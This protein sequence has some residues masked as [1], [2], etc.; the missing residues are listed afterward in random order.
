MHKIVVGQTVF[1]YGMARRNFPAF[2]TARYLM[3]RPKKERVCLVGSGNWYVCR[4][5]SMRI[6]FFFDTLCR[7]S[8]V[9]KIVGYNVARHSDLFE[10][11][12]TQWVFEE[13]FNGEKLTDIINREHENPKYDYAAVVV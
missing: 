12:V 1:K 2:S 6:L 3:T 13:M 7:G 8:A 10:P 5:H 4:P 9:G 11:Q